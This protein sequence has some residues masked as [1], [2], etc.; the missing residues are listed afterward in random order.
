MNHGTK[1][2]VNINSQEFQ[3]MP[4]YLFIKTID[5][6]AEKVT[7]SGIVI[8]N[9]NQSINDRS[10]EGEVVS[11]GSNIDDIKEGTIVVWPSTDGIDLEMPDGDFM[12]LRYKSVIGMKK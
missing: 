9:Q 3:P 7:A 4:D 6:L 11:V 8:P 12:L 5:L 1:Q 10:S 2:Q